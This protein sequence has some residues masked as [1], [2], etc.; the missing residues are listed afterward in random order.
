MAPEDRRASLVVATIPLLCQYGRKV[1]TR[2]IAAAVWVGNTGKEQA[3]YEKSGKDISGAGLPGAI[4]EKFMETA[5]KGM[6]E[7]GFADRAKV[8]DPNKSEPGLQQKL[9][10]TIIV[11][12]TTNALNG[13]DIVVKSQ[14][15]SLSSTVAS[16]SITS[17]TADLSSANSGYGAQVTSASQSGGGPLTAPGRRPKL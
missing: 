5:S 1:T 7:Q 3:V 15:A 17:A 4:W 6:D 12:I 11:D 8:G 14:N 10:A 16:S 13:G 2:Q 9:N